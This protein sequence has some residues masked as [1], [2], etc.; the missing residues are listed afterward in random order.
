MAVFFSLPN[1]LILPSLTFILCPCEDLAVAISIAQ[2]WYNAIDL[3]LIV[4]WS[5]VDEVSCSIYS[6][7]ETLES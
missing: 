2:L 5:G 7:F 1:V 6:F 4:T 3:Q